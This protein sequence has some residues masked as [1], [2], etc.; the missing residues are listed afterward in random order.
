MSSNKTMATEISVALGLSGYD[1]TEESML[2]IKNVTKEVSSEIM[3]F[4]SMNKKNLQL[5]IKFHNLGLSIRNK[6]TFVGEKEIE[7]TGNS[8]IS[9]GI[10]MAQDLIESSGNFNIAYSIKQDSKVVSNSS[11]GRLEK[12]MSG[13]NIHGSRYENWFQKIAPNEYQDFY[14][15]CDGEKFTGF[16][17][18]LE[19]DKAKKSETNK[20]A[21]R[22]YVANK[23]KNNPYAKEKYKIFCKAVSENTANIYNQYLIGKNSNELKSIFWNFFR[24]DSNQYILCGTEK[25]KN[26]AVK[27]DSVKE[28]DRKYKIKSIQA[29]AKVAGQP[30]VIISFCIADAE[31]TYTFNMRI[32]LRWSHGKFCG[33]PEAKIYKEFSYKD[34]PWNTI[35]I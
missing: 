23:I 33:N 20:K 16:K 2:K 14:E 3:N 32:E 18:V 1:F 12:I 10:S 8:K 26:F 5:C 13:M 22:D 15:A 30:E 19:W 27:V 35:I 34:L 31:K 29:F 11:P 25:R 9:T 17:T 28:I 6:D 7:W 24:M 21:F 4:S